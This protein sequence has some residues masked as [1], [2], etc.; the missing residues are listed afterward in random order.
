MNIYHVLHI[1]RGVLGMGP[2]AC[3]V[4]PWVHL[5]Y[6]PAR[7]TKSKMSSIFGDETPICHEKDRTRFVKDIPIILLNVILVDGKM[8]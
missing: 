3:D 2:C 8:F 4:P 5:H 1:C 6:N 7:I